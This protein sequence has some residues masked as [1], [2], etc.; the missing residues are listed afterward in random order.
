VLFNNQFRPLPQVTEPKWV[1]VITRSME[2][3]SR[4][5]TLTQIRHLVAMSQVAELK[6]HA[7]VQVRIA[8]IPGQWM[9]PKPG[10]FQKE[11][12]NE[13]VDLGERMGADPMSWQTALP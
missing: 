8:S 1:N 7:D 13:L 12:M 3:T 9:P 6:Y 2:T 10:S 4:A 11:T 5:A